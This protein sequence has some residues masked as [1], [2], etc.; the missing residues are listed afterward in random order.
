MCICI[1]IYICMTVSKEKALILKVLCLA[2]PYS[3][4]IIKIITTKLHFNSS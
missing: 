2:A 4:N 1:Y 3:D